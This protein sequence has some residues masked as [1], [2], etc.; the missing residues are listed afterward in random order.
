MPT[1]TIHNHK[2]GERTDVVL[3]IS[4]MEALVATN[5][6][7]EVVFWET[8]KAIGDPFLLGRVKTSKD[9]QQ[10]LKDIKASHRGS[11]IKTGNITEV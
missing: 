11:T 9:F 5:K 2:T 4:E 8:P 6:H 7:L 1:Y 3:S 10:R